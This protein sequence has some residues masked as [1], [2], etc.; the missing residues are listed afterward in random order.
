MS[1]VS[2][3]RLLMQALKKLKAK[4]LRLQKPKLK[5]FAA[6]TA[7]LQ[8]AW[9]KLKAAEKALTYK[10][11]KKTADLAKRRSALI[12]SQQAVDNAKEAARISAKAQQER[13]QTGAGTSSTKVTRVKALS[14]EGR[15]AAY[16]SGRFGVSRE[17]QTMNAGWT[18]EYTTDGPVFNYNPKDDPEADDKDK[19][20]KNVTA[21]KAYDSLKKARKAYRNAL[22]TFDQRRIDVAKEKLDAQELFME[23]LAGARY[24]SVK[25][26]V[27]S[28]STE[29]D[30]KWQVSQEINRLPKKEITTYTNARAEQ[31]KLRKEIEHVRTLKG[32]TEISQQRT[33]V[34]NAQNQYDKIAYELSEVK[35]K[36]EY[37]ISTLSESAYDR[38]V[39]DLTQ[40]LDQT[41]ARLAELSTR[42]K[43]M[44]VKNEERLADL[45]KRYFAAKK[46]ADEILLGKPEEDTKGA[47]R[48]PIAENVKDMKGAMRTLA[49]DEKNSDIKPLIK[50]NQK[51]KGASSEEQRVRRA[52]EGL[53]K[54][55]RL[56]TSCRF[57]HS[58]I[59]AVI[60]VT[61]I[62]LPH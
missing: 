54:K 13:I 60:A 43:P 16:A 40:Q 42:L 51:L 28:T 26:V 19:K 49:R 27:G 29:L 12:L 7:H 1:C 14:E 30:T 36:Q 46:T 56:V 20:R 52:A 11:E 55:D 38:R 50:Q 41:K 10:D 8:D 44:E 53:A 45:T 23:D 37:D 4:S 33:A 3:W 2:N 9:A 5:C 17:V 47:T 21:K 39:K 59:F 48:A 25:E 22:T 35:R 34:R 15:K 31:E 62:S 58:N 6:L 24:V 32:Q 18:V 57:I 61:H